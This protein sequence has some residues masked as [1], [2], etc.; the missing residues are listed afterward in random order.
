MLVKLG[1]VRIYDFQYPHLIN[2]FSLSNAV[3]PAFFLY[4]GTESQG[5]HFVLNTLKAHNKTLCVCY[6]TL[7]IKRGYVVWYVR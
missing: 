4:F 6:S 7:R 3:K 2:Y 1:F 5:S